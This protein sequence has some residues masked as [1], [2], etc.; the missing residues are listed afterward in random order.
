MVSDGYG[1]S[2]QTFA[3]SLWQLKNNLPYNDVLPLDEILVGASRT[4]S[5]SSLV[6]DSAAGA[7]AFSCG[8]KTYNNAISGKHQLL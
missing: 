5:A 6:T 1:P 2:S 4:R 8:L 3:R 7:T